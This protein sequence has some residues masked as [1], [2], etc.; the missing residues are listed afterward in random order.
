MLPVLNVTS[1][2]GGFVKCVRAR[3]SA[4]VWTEGAVTS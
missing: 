2:N 3:A 1:I 4:C